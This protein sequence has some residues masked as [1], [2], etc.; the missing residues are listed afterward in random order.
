MTVIFQLFCVEDLEL[1]GDE[2]CNELHKFIKGAINDYRNKYARNGTENPFALSTA[3]QHISPK[4]TGSEHRSVA[5]SPKNVP[6]NMPEMLQNRLDRVSQQ[7]D[8]IITRDPPDTRSLKQP[9][10]ADLIDQLITQRN[11]R[12]LS[13]D[14]KKQIVRWALGCEI[15]YF[16]F[17][18][19]L[20]FIKQKAY[21][22]FEGKT[23]Q[24]PKGPD[25]RYSPFH[26]E[27]PLYR[28]LENIHVEE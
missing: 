23:D 10:D 24:R 27:H 14:G 3:D 13:K 19:P 26:P 11:N 16:N 28:D 4:P 1:L 12:R 25:S 22:W 9:H 15:N 17:Y 7:L 2:G 6:L 21:R 18:H 20:L 8:A 5:D